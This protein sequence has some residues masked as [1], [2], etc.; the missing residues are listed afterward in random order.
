MYIDIHL[1]IQAIKHTYIYTYI[2]HTQGTYV[3][4]HI[5]T[6]TYIHEYICTHIYI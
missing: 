3:H 2:P 6:I 1:Y 4:K 5:Y